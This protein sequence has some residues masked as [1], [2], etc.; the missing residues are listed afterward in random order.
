MRPTNHFF[1][2][3]DSRTHP[4]AKHRATPALINIKIINRYQLVKQCR[5]SSL[6]YNRRKYN[7]LYSATTERQEY[8]CPWVSMIFHQRYRAVAVAVAV[9]AAV[10]PKPQLKLMGG[11]LEGRASLNRRLGSQSLLQLRSHRLTTACSSTEALPPQCS[12]ERS[13]QL[14]LQSA[15]Q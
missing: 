4:Y 6:L 2:N 13:R 7:A 15:A 8:V 10:A 11:F 5:Q 9:A 1:S 12:T 3:V 14:R